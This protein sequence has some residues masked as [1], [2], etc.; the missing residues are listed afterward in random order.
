MS[1]SLFLTVSFRNCCIDFFFTFSV[2]ESRD[3]FCFSNSKH[4]K[5]AKHNICYKFLKGN[6]NLLFIGF[7]LNLD[8][9]KKC[10]GIKPKYLPQPEQKHVFFM[11]KLIKTN[12]NFGIFFLSL[13][14][15]KQFIILGAVLRMT[16]YTKKSSKQKVV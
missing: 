12:L 10:T 2:L 8:N 15:K 6:S 16:T 3:S 7:D 11:Q 1:F 5:N 14:S 9:N 4:I 13:F